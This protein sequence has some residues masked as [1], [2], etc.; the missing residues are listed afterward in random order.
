MGEENM[1]RTRTNRRG[2]ALVVAAG[3]ACA[4]GSAKAAGVYSTGSVYDENTTVANFV[5]SIADNATPGGITTS[6][7]GDGLNG[8]KSLM[9]SAFAANR[10]GVVSFDNEAPN[11]T[12][13]TFNFDIQYGVGQQFTVLTS[14]Q[15]RGDAPTSSA[16]P[17]SGGA[18]NRTLR[19]ADANGGAPSAD[20]T[21]TFPT[22][23]G[24]TDVGFT[25]LSRT[26]YDATTVVTV[27]ATFSDAST[28]DL[29]SQIGNGRELDDTFYRFTAPAGAV[30]SP[31]ARGR[32]GLTW[33]TSASL[34]SRSRARWACWR[35]GG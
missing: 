35:W 21:W 28:K 13:A 32:S 23:A 10:G 29:A 33:T 17:I 3:V 18:G 26:T 19:Q 20:Y 8:F 25:L 2:C 27:T 31:P 9:E 16:T 12:P 14:T 34:W 1:S 4:G 6:G 11:P 5:D 22:S 24:I 15:V 30:S 7:P